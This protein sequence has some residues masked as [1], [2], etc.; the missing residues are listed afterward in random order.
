A[1][2]QIQLARERLAA[3]LLDIDTEEARAQQTLARLLDTPGLDTFETVPLVALVA[4]VSEI[5]MAAAESALQQRPENGALNARIAQAEAEAAL[6]RQSRYP[7]L[8]VNVTYFNIGD[9]SVPTSADGRD[10]FAVGVTVSVPLDR[11]RQQAQAEKARLRTAQA[12]AERAALATDITTTLADLRA[13]L[14]DE[15]AQIALYTDRL[16]PQAN[17]TVESVL[18]AYATGQAD[19]GA[20]LDAE[21]T[22][23]DLRLALDAAC[24][25]YAHAV[26]AL[27]RTLGTPPSQTQLGAPNDE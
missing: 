10:A 16:L 17:A 8:G 13:Q 21:R 25:R 24:A 26:A 18:A 9:R 12:E 4:P 20:L 6:A 3:R 7:N 22:R 1:I 27:E 5:N 23:F 15:A 2:L 19:Y 14:R 11:A